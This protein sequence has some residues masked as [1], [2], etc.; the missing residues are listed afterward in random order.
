MTLRRGA[1]LAL[2]GL[3][4]AGVRAAP[5]Q[6]SQFGIRS[7][8]SPGRW[9]S[10]RARSTGGAFGPFDPLSPLA[11]AALADEGRL[12]ATG[13]EATSYRR[14]AVSG[15]SAALRTSRFPVMGLAGPVK[16]QVVLGGGF[17][18][19][20]DR[21][22][23][24]VTRDTLVIAGTP[25]PFTDEVTSD[26]GVSDLWLAAA[27]RLGTR[28]ALGV[29]FHILT[30]STSNSATRIFDD[31]T[32]Y[33]SVRQ[34]DNVRYDALGFSGSLLVDL[35]SELRLAGFVRSDTHLRASVGDNVTARTNLPTTVGGALRWQLSPSARLAAALTWRS[36]ADAGPDAFNTLG[37]SAGAELGPESS[38][39]RFG[40]RG[41]M[42]PFGPGARAP[43][44]W[45]VAVGTGRSVADGRGLIDIGLERL[46][47]SGGGLREHVWTVL[48]GLTLRP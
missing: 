39:F 46:Q 21:T 13:M 1:A 32:S 34:T 7:L 42:L 2:A 43:T 3:F 26:G 27:S 17:T 18:T 47:R 4:G 38:P 31:S 41:G 12:T 8:G 33:R 20:L 37:W 6:D 44:E 30:G 48:V 23:D 28:L 29:G 22:Y 11:E 45:G 19:Y 14:A 40:V 16:G 10:V 5:A 24:V 36:W 25:Q 35:A 9:E 15:S